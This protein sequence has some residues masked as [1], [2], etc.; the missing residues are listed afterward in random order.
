MSRTVALML[1]VVAVG[2]LAAG[3]QTV[4]RTV[5]DHIDAAGLGSQRS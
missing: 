1:T 2:V 4:A 5:A 3:S